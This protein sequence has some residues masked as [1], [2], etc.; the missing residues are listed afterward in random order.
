MDKKKAT[1]ARPMR[2]VPQPTTGPRKRRGIMAPAPRI[3]ELRLRGYIMVSAPATALT[4]NRMRICSVAPYRLIG[5]LADATQCQE[6]GAIAP[7]RTATA[8]GIAGVA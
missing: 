5:E 1:E 8:C 7:E 4:A 2:D 6:D 3:L